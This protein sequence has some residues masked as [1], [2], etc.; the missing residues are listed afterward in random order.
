MIRAEH[1]RLSFFSSNSVKSKTLKHKDQLSRLKS[2]DPEF[3]KFL[4]EN[5]EELL[6]FND[7]ETDDE[8]QTDDS[9]NEALE[10]A[11]TPEPLED[12]SKVHQVYNNYIY[13]YT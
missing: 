13:I 9:E 8:L 11:E 4:E 2:K 3:Y 6:E 5:D 10:E 1:S 7:S 12:Q